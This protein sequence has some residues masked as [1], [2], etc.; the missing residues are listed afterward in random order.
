MRSSPSSVPTNVSPGRA[1][2]GRRTPASS[3]FTAFPTR[4]ARSCCKWTMNRKGSSRISVRRLALC[5]CASRGISHA[6]RS[7][8]RNEGEKAGPGEGKSK[9]SSAGWRVS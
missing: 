6:L 3:P 4:K 9:E 7:S 5:R 8:L 2:T 1:R